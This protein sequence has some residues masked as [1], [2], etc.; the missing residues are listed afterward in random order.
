[1]RSAFLVAAIAPL[2]VAAAPPVSP[3]IYDFQFSGNGCPHD[4]GS[5]K[6]TSAV[7]DDSI[8][9]TFGQIKGDDTSNCGIHLQAKGGSEGW[10]V[11]IKEVVYTGTVSLKP[12]SE[13]DTITQVFFSEDASATVSSP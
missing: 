11:A 9:F 2:F 3:K 13:L 6:A 8:S 5:V 1:M 4:S 7:L 12:G 10:Q